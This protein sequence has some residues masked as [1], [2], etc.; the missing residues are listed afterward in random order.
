MRTRR[1]VMPSKVSFENVRTNW[2][3]LAATIDWSIQDCVKDL[4]LWKR[5][6]MPRT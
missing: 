2:M 1:G 6:W 4:P 3:E 5:V